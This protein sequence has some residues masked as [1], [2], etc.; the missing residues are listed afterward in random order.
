MRAGNNHV[1]L[2]NSTEHAGPSFIALIVFIALPCFSN[3]RLNGLTGTSRKDLYTNL[4]SVHVIL[5]VSCA[6]FVFQNVN[7]NVYVCIIT[8]S[9]HRGNANKMHSLTFTTFLSRTIT[10]PEFTV[11]FLCFFLVFLIVL[12]SKAR[13]SLFPENKGK[14]LLHNSLIPKTENIHTISI[15]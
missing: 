8:P 12:K 14:I 7:Q 1:V 9:K 10:P 2:K 4:R 5:F 13:G 3:A 11:S 15:L 6:L